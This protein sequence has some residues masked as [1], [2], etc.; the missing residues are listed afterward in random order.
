MEGK[1]T[2]A[3]TSETNIDDKNPKNGSE[4]TLNGTEKS[5]PKLAASVRLERLMGHGRFQHFQI[6]VFLALVSLLVFI[7]A[8]ISSN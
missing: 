6:W 7:L 4:K 3:G 2:E 8:M 5:G 1:S